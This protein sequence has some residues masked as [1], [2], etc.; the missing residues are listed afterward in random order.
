M[1]TWELVRCGQRL[2][3]DAPQNDRDEHDEDNSDVANVAA[4][5]IVASVVTV[6]Y[7]GVAYDQGTGCRLLRRIQPRTIR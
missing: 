7:V 4:V 6:G 3:A 2:T 1:D 5:V